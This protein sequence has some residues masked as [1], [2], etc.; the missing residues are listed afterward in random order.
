VV[1][2]RL[3]TRFK[4]KNAQPLRGLDIVLR[5][6]HNQIMDISRNVENDTGKLKKL[7]NSVACATQ[8]LLLLIKIKYDLDKSKFCMLK[9]HLNA[10]VTESTGPET[11]GWE[12]SIDCSMTHLLRTSLSKSSR[13]AAVSQ[14][15][16][17]DVTD[18]A[19]VKRHIKLVIDRIKNP[20]EESSAK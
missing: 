13:D 20:E 2:K 15:T 7:G 5:E 9:A 10:V 17:E 12:E 18:I 1:Q 6:I 19:K 8:L 4:D 11:Q 16:M 3:L 14:K